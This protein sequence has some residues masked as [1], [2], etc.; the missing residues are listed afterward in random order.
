MK[1]MS[2]A[3]GRNSVLLAVFAVLTA[4]L[5][6]GT[7]LGTRDE[8]AAARRAAEEKALLEIV[9]RS[10]HDNSMLDDR[11]PAPLDGP[12]LR[13]TAQRDVFRARQDGD[14]VAVI[15]PSHAPERSSG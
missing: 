15:V 6:A 1:E 14:V 7:F 5:V 3:I 13:L 8:I 10:R 12:Y 2:R 4:L 11:L 9:P